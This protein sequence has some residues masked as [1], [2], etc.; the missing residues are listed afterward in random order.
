MR[1]KKR[2]QRTTT[3][4]MLHVNATSTSTSHLRGARRTCS[5][6]R[7]NLD[8]EED[9]TLSWVHALAK[10]AISTQR[11][12][13]WVESTLSVRTQQPMPD[14]RAQALPQPNLQLTLSIL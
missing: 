2:L 7:S 4:I 3:L 11:N 10:T 14:R 12:A 6:I 1:W 5:D 9:R 8:R 13:H